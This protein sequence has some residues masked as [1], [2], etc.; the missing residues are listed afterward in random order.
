MKGREGIHE[1]LVITKAIEELIL[2]R[3]SDEHINTLAMKEGMATLRQAALQ[4]VYEGKISI[5]E[6]LRLTE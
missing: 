6:A 1:V 3:P 2:Q 5:E 4:K